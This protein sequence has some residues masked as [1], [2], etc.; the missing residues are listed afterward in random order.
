METIAET[1]VVQPPF[2]PFRGGRIFNVSINSPPWDGEIEED[3]AAR[4][5]KN[6][7]RAQH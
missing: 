3:H 5:N 4:V 6:I 2:P 7:N 1:T